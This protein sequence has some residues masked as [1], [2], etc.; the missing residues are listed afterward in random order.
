[1]CLVLKC[2]FNIERGGV[3][4]IRYPAPLLVAVG[5]FVC[6]L[7]MSRCED[8]PWLVRADRGWNN[9]VGVRAPAEFIVPN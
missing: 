1:M 4:D 7:V 8:H 2:L 5:I 9:K 6:S 3:D